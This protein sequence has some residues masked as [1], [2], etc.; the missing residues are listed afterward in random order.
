M[1]IVLSHHTPICSVYNHIDL[2][3]RRLV[4]K[5]VMAKWDTSMDRVDHMVVGDYK[6]VWAIHIGRPVDYAEQI[7]LEDATGAMFFPYAVT[8]LDDWPIFPHLLLRHV[9]VSFDPPTPSLCRNSRISWHRSGSPHPLHHNLLPRP[10]VPP[11]HPRIPC[12]AP[13]FLHLVSRIWE[14]LLS[15]P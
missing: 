12:T 3:R 14:S 4:R 9:G 13:L 15:S 2:S 7:A 8:I 1:Y 5:M 11:P 6:R 10:H